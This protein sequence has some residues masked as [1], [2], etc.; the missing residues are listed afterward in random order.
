MCAE[1]KCP[2][3]SESVAAAELAVHLRRELRYA[4]FLCGR[5]PVRDPIPLLLS[6]HC[7]RQTIDQY[8]SVC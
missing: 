3:C 2:L 5:C 6:L 8:R 4:P 7:V 1:A